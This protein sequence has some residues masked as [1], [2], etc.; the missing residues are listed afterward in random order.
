MNEK[1]SVFV[2]IF[3]RDKLNRKKEYIKWLK[4]QRAAIKIKTISEFDEAVYKIGIDRINRKKQ[5]RKKNPF[6]GFHGMKL[7]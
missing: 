2:K 5:K 1:K 6:R 3:Y 7:G 4:N